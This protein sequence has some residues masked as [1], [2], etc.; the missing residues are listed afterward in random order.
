MNGVHERTEALK[1][2]NSGGREEWGEQ[3]S[4]EEAIFWELSSQFP[5][6]SIKEKWPTHLK[7][8]SK[9]NHPLRCLANASSCN[10]ISSFIQ[11]IKEEEE[12]ENDS[13]K[14]EEEN[15][16][17]SLEPRKHTYSYLNMNRPSNKVKGSHW[18]SQGK[19]TTARN[20]LSLMQ[21][22]KILKSLTQLGFV[23]NYF[24]WFVLGKMENKNPYG[25]T[26]K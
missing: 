26:W 23:G 6:E 22:S 8:L 25:L 1:F 17:S 14:D 19:P 21:R 18:N 2:S 7:S 15:W 24:V 12:M 3:G 11:H 4:R 16:I 10:L 9:A 5:S 20:L 13:E